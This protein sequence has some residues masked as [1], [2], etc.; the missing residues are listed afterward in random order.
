M[1]RISIIGS[2]GIFASY[3]GFDQLV[4]NLVDK[5][6]PE[7][8]Y[9]VFNSSET[10]VKKSMIPGH[11]KVIRLPFSASGYQGIIYD[12]LSIFI[13]AFVS[14]R[15]LL[16]GSQGAPL[17]IFLRLVTFGRVKVVVN[18]GGI[19]WMRPHLSFFVRL[20]FK[21]CFYLSLYF[22]NKVIIDNEHYLE[23]AP[24]SRSGRSKIRVIPYGG[25]IDHSLAR[26]E[27]GLQAKY[28]FLTGD[29]MLSIS[30]SIEDNKLEELCKFFR[31]R[32][33]LNLVLIS[34][35]SNSA[36]GKY[37]KRAFANDS[38]IH[39]IDGL[40][41][42][43]ELDL[44]RRSCKAYIHT[45]TLCGSA[46]SLIE[47]I[48]AR[49]P[50]FSINV[51]QNLFTLDG[52][53]FVFTDFSDLDRVINLSNLDAYIPPQSHA[54]AFGWPSIVRSYEHCFD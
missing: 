40:Y 52:H 47:M 21:F 23:F 15:L 46:P 20:Y 33:S 2:H 34:N 1:S 7:T 43:P 17:A 6:A 3:G 27:E 53:G 42:K 44:I 19:E 29:Y 5:A 31:S 26:S 38:N 8:S 10:P 51:P 13:A 22:A 37:I 41:E 54:D 18:I 11:C 14:R 9:V 36:Y 28:R 4:N 45:H 25:I 48:V 12:Y 32:P 39:L 30:R 49:R 24:V 50:I 16:L 35:L